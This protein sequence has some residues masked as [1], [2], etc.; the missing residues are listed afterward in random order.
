MI[1]R[2]LCNN[3]LLLPLRVW[4]NDGGGC[5]NPSKVKSVPGLV[6]IQPFIEAVCNSSWDMFTS[7]EV[8]GG[9]NFAMSLNCTGRIYK[10]KSLRKNS[11][12][13]L[14][15]ITRVVSWTKMGQLKLD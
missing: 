7:I 14:V 5:Y 8:D 15:V 12:K 11:R 6:Q 4:S 1:T 9:S 2:T 13:S 3:K 10:Q